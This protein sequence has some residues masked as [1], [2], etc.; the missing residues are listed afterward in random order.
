MEDDA[1]EL[2]YV[3]LETY[4]DDAS[5]SFLALPQDIIQQT[6]ERARG[7]LDASFSPTYA[8]DNYGRSGVFTLA[9]EC[10][11]PKVEAVLPAYKLTSEYQEIMGF[12]AV[13]QQLMGP[14]EDEEGVVD[15][16][17]SSPKKVNQGP[18]RFPFL[19]STSS[20]VMP[21]PEHPLAKEVIRRHSVDSNTPLTS[22]VTSISRP[23][24]PKA[25]DQ[26]D[27]SSSSSSSD[28]DSSL[29]LSPSMGEVG[30]YS[31]KPPDKD[32]GT[33]PSTTFTPDA[34]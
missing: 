21:R 13:G 29:Q 2:C 9:Y 1:R 15:P 17:P 22:G 6:V 4:F 3:M 24:S 27:S 12:L 25:W 7:Y 14:D 32:R 31:P 18:G 5:S 16:G 23:I 30:R 11:K 34:S 28:P 33:P 8:Q 10:I 26:D 19:M 20:K